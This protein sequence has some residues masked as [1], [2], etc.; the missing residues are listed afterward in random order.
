[1]KVGLLDANVL[2]ALAWPSHIHHLAAHAWFSKN[3]TKGWATCPMTQCAFIRISSN[4]KI[5]PDAVTPSEAMELLRQIVAQDHHK[6]WPDDVSVLDEHVRGKFLIGHRQV[7]DA[8]LL[9]LV[10][11]HGGRLVT[12]DKGLL[13]LAS[14]MR[15]D[16]NVIEVVA[17]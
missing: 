4:P 11:R 1:M 10:L 15:C 8:Y 13:S 7:T 16:A 6:F 3:A 12:L 2:I 5:I 14:S 9:A 17:T